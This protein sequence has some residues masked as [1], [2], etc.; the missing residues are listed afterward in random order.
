MET[1]GKEPD[2][3][4]T[5]ANERT[6]LTWLSTSL[7]LTAGGVAMAAVSP[8]VFVPWMR[9]LLAVVLVSLSA[10]AAAMAYPRWRRVQHALR[11]SEPLPPPALAALFGY[12]VAA[13]AVLALV[14]ILTAR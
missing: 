1:P 14:L 5:L 12:G 4:F 2:P 3:R 7:A 6:F 9:T 8:D 10:L 13:V 11:T